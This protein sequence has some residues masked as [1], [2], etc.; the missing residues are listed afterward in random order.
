M[1]GV[2]ERG[3]MLRVEGREGGCSEWRGERGDAKSG[4]GRGGMLRERG[5]RGG[6]C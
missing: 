4:G 2:G 6:A 3:G 1:L 5:E